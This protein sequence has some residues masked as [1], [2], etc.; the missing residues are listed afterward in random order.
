MASTQLTSY[1]YENIEDCIWSIEREYEIVFSAEELQNT[2]R[3]R[4]L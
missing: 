4:N 3:W 2:F 1:D